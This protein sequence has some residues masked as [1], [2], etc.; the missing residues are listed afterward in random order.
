MKAFFTTKH[1][2]ARAADIAKYAEI[3]KGDIHLPLQRHTARIAV[4]RAD[5][6]RKSAD[7]IITNRTNVLLGVR[8]SDCVPIL[9]FDVR[10][11]ACGAVHAGWRGTAKGILKRS[12]HTMVSNC[13]SSVRDIRVAIGPAIRWCCY[14]V[15]K[16]VFEAVKAATGCGEFSHYREGE[17]CLDLPTANVI[18]ARAIGVS[19]SAIWMSGECTYCN[20]LR[21]YSYRYSGRLAGSQGGFIGVMTRR[22]RLQFDHEEQEG[23]C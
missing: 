10:T 18:Q 15:Q 7:A 8:V 22:G 2:G 1:V 9:L 11:R 6:T 19:A 14:Q 17:I 23:T 16:E 12:I 4:L 13:R 5:M 20:P 3:R 21:F